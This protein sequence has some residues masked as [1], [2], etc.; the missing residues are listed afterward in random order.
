MIYQVSKKNMEKIKDTLHEE[1]IFVGRF[2]K[3]NREGFVE[4]Y[5]FP[6]STIVLDENKIGIAS[7]LTVSVLYSKSQLEKKADIKLKDIK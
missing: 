6:P 5:T 1:G 3:E 2:R 4:V 7:K